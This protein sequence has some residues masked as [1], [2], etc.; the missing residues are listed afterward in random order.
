LLR[1]PL[2]LHIPARAFLCLFSAVLV[3]PRQN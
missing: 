2:F 3:L 1:T